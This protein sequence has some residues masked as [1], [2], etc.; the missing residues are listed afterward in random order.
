MLGR[1]ST[2]AQPQSQPASGND[3]KPGEQGGEGGNASK[4]GR[5]GMPGATDVSCRWSSCP[6]P[7]PRS[8]RRRDGGGG[9]PLLLVCRGQRVRHGRCR[10][11]YWSRCAYRR[12]T[13][14]GGSS[15]VRR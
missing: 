7:S 4:I 11:R 5:V 14:Q 6:G 12:A 8:R 2:A 13:G 9:G 1:V 10:D 15:A 3:G